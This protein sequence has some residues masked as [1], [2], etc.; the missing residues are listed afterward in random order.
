MSQS[1]LTAPVSM[2]VADSSKMNSFVG[3]PFPK[4]FFF[5]MRHSES[6]FRIMFEI[7]KLNRVLFA[8]H[9]Y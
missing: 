7:I 9:I 1:V 4:F 5:G 3:M 2:P 8:S 6:E